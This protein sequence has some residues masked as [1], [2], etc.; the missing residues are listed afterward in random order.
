MQWVMNLRLRNKQTFW[1]KLSIRRAFHAMRIQ[2][3]GRGK[4]QL[5]GSRKT[6]KL[7]LSQSQLGGYVVNQALGTKTASGLLYVLMKRTRT[8]Q[9]TS[10]TSGSMVRTKYRLMLNRAR[11]RCC[12]SPTV[13]SNLS[14]RFAPPKKK[15]PA[16]M[17]SP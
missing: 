9:K 14:G 13:E 6:G 10:K 4:G 7:L 12:P 8:S 11:G 17:N 3:N 15:D 16:A 5:P 2:K 1:T